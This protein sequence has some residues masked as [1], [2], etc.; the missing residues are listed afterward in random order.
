[1]EETVDRSG[2]IRPAPT[3]MTLAGMMNREGYHK[4]ERDDKRNREEEKW[5]AR[6]KGEGLRVFNG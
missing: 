4:R 5:R 3:T 1:M 2:D 6:A